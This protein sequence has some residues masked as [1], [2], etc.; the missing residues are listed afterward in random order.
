MVQVRNLYLFVRSQ[1]FR[2]NMWFVPVKAFLDVEV[3]NVGLDFE[4]NL[5]NETVTY[6]NPQTNETHTRVVPKLKITR[7]DLKL[8]PKLVKFNIGGS[9]VA[10]VVDVILP[11]FTRI[12]TVILE[13][14]V[15][16][17]VQD[18]ELPALFND[19]VAESK[20]FFSLGE[21]SPVAAWANTTIDY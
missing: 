7:C 8:N 20:G 10:S 21:M 16:A 6:T 19:M 5:W 14:R 1:D 2:Y 9:L 3:A 18:E 15:R 11:M 4:A 13:K 17:V 12:I